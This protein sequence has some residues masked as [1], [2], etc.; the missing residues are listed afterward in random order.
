[1]SLEDAILGL[2]REPPR[3]P[4]VGGLNPT[5]Q[6][7]AH[8]VETARGEAM[9]DAPPDLRSWVDG[10]DDD[11]RA[12]REVERSLAAAEM[13]EGWID[14]V[15]APAAERL[16][17]ASDDVREPSST[18]F[19]ATYSGDGWTLTLG[20]EEQGRLYV[21]IDATAAPIDVEVL[22]DELAPPPTL[23][24]NAGAAAILGT[25]EDVLGGPADFNPWPSLRI[26][27]GGAELTLR[28]TP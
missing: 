18:P 15:P 11:D 22:L 21:A 17:A 24:G 2:L 10:M 9:A 28:R 8:L 23:P 12:A 13:L 4:D 7:F 25:P 19:P 6:V 5:E 26:R 16:A 20:I 1:M 27:V 14:R 3:S